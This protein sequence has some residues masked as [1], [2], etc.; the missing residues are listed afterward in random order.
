[1]LVAS[2]VRELKMG[3]SQIIPETPEGKCPYCGTR[4]EYVLVEKIV[5]W[6]EVWE[7]VPNNDTIED[8]ELIS[9]DRIETVERQFKCPHCGENLTS[10]E[11][12]MI[13]GVDNP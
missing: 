4:L 6:W 11:V 8:N 5:S 10:E 1:M 12:R 9:S 3:W 7:G 2:L 13:F